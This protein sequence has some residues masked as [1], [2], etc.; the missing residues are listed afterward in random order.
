MICYLCGAAIPFDEPPSV[1]TVTVPS[2]PR[3][4][5]AD[6]ALD[7]WMELFVRRQPEQPESTTYLLHRACIQP[8]LHARVPSALTMGA[9]FRR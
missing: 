4:T 5:F 8:V 2:K 7:A 1:L 3:A 9:V 6:P